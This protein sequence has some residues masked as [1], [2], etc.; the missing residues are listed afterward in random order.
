MKSVYLNI[1][2]SYAKGKKKS[3]EIKLKEKD[4]KYEKQLENNVTRSFIST[5][6]HL[7]PEI[8]CKF[9]NELICEKLGL[10]Y[11]NTMTMPEFVLQSPK[12]IL[13][14]RTKESKNQRLLII[15]GYGNWKPEKRAETDESKPDAWILWENT[16]VCIESKLHSEPSESQIRN[17]CKKWFGDQ[18]D[19]FYITWEEIQNKCESIKTNGCD[20]KDEFLLA[21]LGEFLELE[22]FGKISRQHLERAQ[23]LGKDDD[24]DYNFLKVLLKKLSNNLKPEELFN[25]SEYIGKEWK[26]GT[27]KDSREVYIMLNNMPKKGLSINVDFHEGNLKVILYAATVDGYNEIEKM[28]RE[29]NLI[30]KLKAFKKDIYMEAYIEH[31]RGKSLQGKGGNRWQEGKVKLDSSS[32]LDEAIEKLKEH[33]NSDHNKYH[34]N[35]GKRISIY[36]DY[37]DEFYNKKYEE[38]IAVIK[39][40]ISGL[41]NVVDKL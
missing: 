5:L 35:I 4:E 24:E 15:Q 26:T 12:G 8:C 21:Q 34:K 36:I 31:K 29:K 14:P 25:N 19:K 3:K 37:G 13:G 33:Y 23:L 39:Q 2:H 16:A 22:G 32:K 7:S 20:K 40:D 10:A 18:V 38:Q 27:I 1:F 6:A 11:I 28:L 9:L 41:V 17:H 30:N